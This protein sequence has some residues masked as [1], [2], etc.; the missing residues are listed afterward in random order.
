MSIGPDDKPEEQKPPE[1]NKGGRPRYQPKP[2][3]R[4][5]VHALHA[6]GFSLR[7][8]AKK[9]GIDVTTLRKAFREDLRQAH[10]EI[11]A[12]MVASL[13][14][15]ANGGAWGAAKYWLMCFGGPE[16]K[17]PR[18]AEDVLP[19]GANA[20]NTTIVIRGGLPPQV[21]TDAGPDIEGVPPKMNGR[22]N[23]ADPDHPA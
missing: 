2:Q 7:F 9:V 12:A 5:L 6:H 10:E 8:I 20:G 22:G 21:Y 11:K 13:L 1:R 19:P 16:W 3:D 4:Q 14:R 15:S 23:G 17:P 18:E